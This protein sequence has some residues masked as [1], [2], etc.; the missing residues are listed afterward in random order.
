[1]TRR[2]AYTRQLRP[3]TAVLF[4]LRQVFY[5]SR[6][7]PGPESVRAQIAAA[8]LAHVLGLDR[9]GSWLT[10][11]AS[12]AAAGVGDPRLGAYV[13][14]LHAIDCYLFGFDQGDRARATYLEQRRWLDLGHSGDLL[15]VL[16]WDLLMRGKLAEARA[17]FEQREALVAAIG[18][19]G[20]ISTH[21][22]GA[23][24]LAM[25]GDAR[26]AREYLAQLRATANDRL[27]WQRVDLLF[28]TLMTSRDRPGVHPHRPAAGR[29][30][31]S[32]AGTRSGGAA[33]AGL[34]GAQYP[35]RSGARATPAVESRAFAG[36]RRA[37]VAGP[38]RG[39]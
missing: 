28:A 9:I 8:H 33:A 34:H 21:A 4:A 19:A 1:M 39:G 24:L 5:V 29:G 6:I 32:A 22:A 18:Q 35:A 25:R 26:Q 31:R 38:A 12:S 11:R 14:W 20:P 30:V 15:L 3:T 16:H 17:M 2:L 13:A 27:P 37:R 7:G 10:A 36:R 23:C